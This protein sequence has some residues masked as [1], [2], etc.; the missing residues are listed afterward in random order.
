VNFA[1]AT[2]TSST[3]QFTILNTAGTVSITA[4]G[5]D[6]FTFLVGGTPFGG[7]VLA[8]FTLSATST[9]LGNCGVACATGDSFSE[10]GYTGSFSYTVAS[11]PFIGSILLQGTFTTNATPASSGA[12]LSDTIDGTG[13]SFSGTETVTNTG[14]ILMSSDFLNF[15]GVG[16]EAGSWAFSAGAPNFGV[17]PPVAGQSKPTTGQAFTD[18]HSDTFSSEPAPSGGTPEPATMSLLGS[19]LVGLGLIGRKRFAR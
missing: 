13:G 12:T 1:V 10:Q 14:G 4:T 7:P 9:Q 18:N 6:F 2:P 5:Q 19:A 3:P 16:N 8:N 11:G 17:N 15:A